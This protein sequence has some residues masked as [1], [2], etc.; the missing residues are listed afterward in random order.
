MSM[1]IFR[2]P[3]SPFIG[4]RQPLEPEKLPADILAVVSA[5]NPPFGLPAPALWAILRAW[6]LGQGQI[7]VLPYSGILAAGGVGA[8]VTTYIPIFRRRR[9]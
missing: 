1:G 4:G 7:I 8:A 9:R 3:P 6:Q 2:Q 5:D